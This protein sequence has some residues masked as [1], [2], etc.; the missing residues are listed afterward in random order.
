M[1]YLLKDML[2]Y[3]IKIGQNERKTEDRFFFNR[4]KLI[5]III[6][7]ISHCFFNKNNCS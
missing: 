2:I 6:F 5:L 7:Y 4:D 3:F 1:Q